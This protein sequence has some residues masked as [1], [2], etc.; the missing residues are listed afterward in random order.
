MGKGLSE[1]QTRL[2]RY[3]NDKSEPTEFADIHEACGLSTPGNTLRAL[4]S[5]EKR[6][7]ARHIET[8][9]RYRL[10]KLGWKLMNEWKKTGV[11][12]DELRKLLE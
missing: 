8:E 5:L 4:R 12:P 11:M 1:A 10:S 2:L 6:G 9:P 3:L 7:F